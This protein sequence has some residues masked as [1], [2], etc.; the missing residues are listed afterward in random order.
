MTHITV[1]SATWT[2]SEKQI[3]RF[4]LSNSA[5][6]ELILEMPIDPLMLFSLTPS[7]KQLELNLFIYIA[8]IVVEKIKEQQ[9]YNDE[10]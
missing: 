6:K 7:E 5:T 3:M 10:R 9:I 1:S 8:Y 2:R 4:F